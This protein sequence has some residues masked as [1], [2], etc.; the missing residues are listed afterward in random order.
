MMAALRHVGKLEAGAALG[1]LVAR[2][3][4]LALGVLVFLAVLVA[5]VT[6]WV[7]GSDVRT[8]RVSRVLL[9]WRG[10]ASCPASTSATTP[11][12]PVSRPQR[13]PWLRRPRNRQ[14]DHAG[15]RGG[16]ES[17]PAWSA[18]IYEGRPGSRQSRWDR[19]LGSVIRWRCRT[20]GIR[21]LGG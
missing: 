1:G 14:R 21:T 11:G 4:L 17:A 7:F 18:I 12:L 3:G 13:W 15:R 2:L 16:R 5:G 6:C 8:E 9:A 20:V 10:N 19:W